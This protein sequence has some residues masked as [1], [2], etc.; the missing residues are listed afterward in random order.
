V[1]QSGNVITAGVSNKLTMFV[2]DF[3]SQSIEYISPIDSSTITLAPNSIAYYLNDNSAFTTTL[4]I[5]TTGTQWLTTENNFGR[6]SIITFTNT[7]GIDMTFDNIMVTA[8]VPEPG[9]GALML[10][11]TAG[12]ATLY[13]RRRRG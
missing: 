5:E 3:D 1:D 12:V 6:V 8:L 13:R 9:T 4:D 10:L 7:V 2:N 11:S